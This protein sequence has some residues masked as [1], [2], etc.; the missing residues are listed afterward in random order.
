M[1]DNPDLSIDEALNHLL[2]AAAGTVDYET[3]NHLRVAREACY[4]A[5]KSLEKAALKVQP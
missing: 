5:K 2:E 3:L 4:L 1:K